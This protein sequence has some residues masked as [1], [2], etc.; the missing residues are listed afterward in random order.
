MKK[1]F[2][3]VCSGIGMGCFTFVAML[4]I[5]SAVTGDANAFFATKTGVEWLRLAVCFV[6]ISTGFYVP[7]LI[8]DNDN[9]A[10][11]F[12]T[13]VHMLIGTVVYL[14]TA[15]FAGWMK[16]NLGTT[17]VYISLALV[18]AGT[19]WSIFMCISKIQAKKINAKIRAK[20][21]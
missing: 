4:F 2:K 7:S 14:F 20:Q 21:Q 13:L 6:V 10:L 3:K 19:F 8:Y 17:V 15:H 5:A 16:G 12:R 1:V 9:I 18:A 11:W